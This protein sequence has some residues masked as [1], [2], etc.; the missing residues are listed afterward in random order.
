MFLSRVFQKLII[1]FTWWVNRKDSE[2][3]HLFSG[4]FLGLDNIGVFDRSK[5]LP[6]GG[7]LEQ[8]DGTGVDG[9]LCLDDDVDGA[10][11]VARQPRVRRTSRRSSSSTSWRSPTR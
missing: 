4:G 6:G 1:N 5:P 9:V 10:R 11:A 7:T 2:G 3:N 8:A